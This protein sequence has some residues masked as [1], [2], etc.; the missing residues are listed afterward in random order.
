[1][2]VER[3][4]TLLRTDSGTVVEI[5]FASG[6]NSVPTFNRVFKKLVGVSPRAYRGENLRR[7]S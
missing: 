4:K 2:R 3:A 6:F 7:E 1:M 5:A